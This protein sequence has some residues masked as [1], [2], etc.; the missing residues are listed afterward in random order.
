MKKEK[1]S[2]TEIHGQ[3]AAEVNRVFVSVSGQTVSTYM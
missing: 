1:I 3:N 2:Y